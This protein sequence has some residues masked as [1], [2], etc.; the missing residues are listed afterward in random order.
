VQKLKI[1]LWRLFGFNPIVNLDFEGY[2]AFLEKIG[3]DGCKFELIDGDM[4][5]AVAVWRKGV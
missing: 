5:M 2:K 4:P 3:L 1:S